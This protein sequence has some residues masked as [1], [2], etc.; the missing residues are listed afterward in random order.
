MASLKDIRRRITST[1]S[2][3]K[4][5]RA[6]KLVAAAKLRRAQENILKARPYAVT[7]HELIS[8]LATRADHHDHP[9]LEERVPERV[10]FVVLTSD[11]GLCGGFN[12]NILR[13][14][15][16]YLRETR[17]QRDE[18]RLVVVGRKGRDY[19]QYRKVKIQRYFDG[20]DVNTAAE[21]AHEISDTIIQDYLAADL[22]MCQILY[23]EFKSAMSQEITVEQLLPVVP[24]EI[25]VAEDTPADFIYEPNKV[26]ILDTILPMYV[27]VELMRAALESTASEYGARMTAMENATKNAIELIGS[28]TLEYNKARQTAITTELLEIVAGAEALKG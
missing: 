20:L 15:E 27:H 11:R 3:Q 17:D 13:R 6:M 18:T 16:R 28:L 26:Q 19:F 10:M 5:T 7:L 9:L 2:T 14:A 12:T 22:D 1:K 25:D 24:L 4:I 21:R 8:E 23:N